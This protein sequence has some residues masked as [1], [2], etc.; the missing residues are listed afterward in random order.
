MVVWTNNSIS[1][2]KEF[3]NTAREGT[4]EK[5]KEYMNNLIDYIDILEETPKAGK[6][7]NYYISNYE[8]RQIIYKKHRIFYYIN[9]ND[10]VILSIVHT[11][12][13]IKKTFRNLKK[14]I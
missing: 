3:I 6:K 1:N 7:M 14:N 13:D 5:A 11:R 8:V 10:I 9:G 4:E 12:L 2:I